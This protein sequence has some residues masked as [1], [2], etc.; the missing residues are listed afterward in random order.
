MKDSRSHA[1]HDSY[2]RKIELLKTKDFLTTSEVGSIVFVSGSSVSQYCDAGKIAHSR[3][4]AGAG[5]GRRIIKH[6]AVKLFMATNGIRNQDYVEDEELDEI[7]SR[8]VGTADEARELLT[9]IQ[10]I[11]SSPHGPREKVNRI[12]MLLAP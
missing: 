9:Q 7:R 1:G 3:S 10:D 5:K 4:I 12:R 8:V 6:D 2:K 11:V